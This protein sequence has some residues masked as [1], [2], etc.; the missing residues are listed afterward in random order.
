MQR[1]IVEQHLF[2]LHPLHPR[3]DEDHPRLHPLHP[4]RYEGHRIQK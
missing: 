2:Q 4:G 3:R 1:T